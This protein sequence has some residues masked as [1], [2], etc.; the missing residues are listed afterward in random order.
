MIGR[1]LRYLVALVVCVLLPLAGCSGGGSSTK[2]TSKGTEVTVGGKVDVAKAVA[3]TAFLSST[4]AGATNNVF[5]YN[6]QDGAQLGTAVIGSDGSF[7]NLTF[8]LPAT[9]TVLVFKAVVAQGTFRSLVPVDL[10]SPPAAGVITGSNPINIQISQQST[11]ITRAVSALMGLTGLLGDANQTLASATKTYTD[12]AQA[13]VNSGGQILAYSTSGLALSGT[14]SNG[15]LLPARAAST[16]T[17]DDLNNTQLDGRIISAYIPGNNPI[18]NFQVV[19]KATGKGIAGLRTFGLHVAQLKPETAGSNSYWLNYI[20]TGTNPRPSSDPVTTFNST[21][22]AVNVQGYTV[23][24]HGD[25][26]Y[27]AIFGSN[28]KNVSSV[29]YD[30]TLVHRIGISVRSVAVPG[31]VGKTP[32]AYAGPINPQTNAVTANFAVRGVANLIYDFTPAT[33]A[34][35]TNNGAQAFA[36]DIVTAD[37]CNQCHDKLGFS[38]GHFASRPDTKLC[39]MCHTPQNIIG[40][41]QTTNGDFTSF[42]HKIH[43]GEELAPAETILGVSTA[44]VTYP[45]DIRN[46]AMCHKGVDGNNWKTKPTRKACGSCHSATDFA[47]H[48]GGQPTDTSCAA[49][50]TG[51][52]A[53]VE[54]SVAHLPVQDPDPAAPEFGGSNTHTYAGYLPAAGVAV[55]GA[56]VI[57]WDVKSVSR[58]GN[59]NPVIVFRFKKDGVPVVFNTYQAGVVTELMT[60]YTGS[61]SAYFAFG[62]TQDNITAPA[63][64]NAAASAYIKNVWN[65]TTPGTT[66]TL[67]AIGTDGY[68]TLTIKNVIVPDGATMLTGGIGYTYGSATTPL[69]QTD[70]SSLT[71]PAAL[72][73]KWAYNGTNNQ[74]GL[75]VVTPNVWKVATGYT[76]RRTIVSN[77]KCN[78]CHVALGIAPTFHAGQ[79]NDAP[80][81]SFCHNVN[82]VN[83]G[84]GVNAKDAIHAI[85]AGAKRTNKY[86]WEVSAGDK[87]WEISYPGYLRDCEQCHVAGTY[88]FSTTSAVVPNLLPTTVATGNVPATVPTIVTGSETVPGTY[89]APQL[90]VPSLKGQALGAGFSFAGGTGTPTDAV[91]TT[92]IISPIS[93]ACYSCHDTAQAAAHMVANGGSIYEARSTALLKT[94]TCLVCHGTAQNTLNTT[95]PTIKAVHRWW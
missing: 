51:G 85:H 13:V 16:L 8:T 60:G 30:G 54:V 6:A 55:P 52:I 27:T 53:D 95:V 38:G 66:A 39:V 31:V 1:N 14:L 76:A 78:A 33:G 94:E 20:L 59:K 65:G 80:T 5:V 3:K 37:A 41:D 32:G 25:G 89:Y 73:T 62:V 23:I 74:G 70:L 71:V 49:C 29:P 90:N 72:K 43:M 50:H 91:G 83:S 21:T 63:D 69:T 61:P 58:D 79:R 86:S 34:M 64:Y 22:G 26:S 87:Y 45:Q 56:P 92:L 24:D 42:I 57:T 44:E 28:V 11:D 40:T 35:L 15:D 81:C 10:S 75:I 46:C 12:C 9:K 4:S 88:D 84:W 18:V 36:R 17:Y 67:S 68:Y 77:A 2:I 48:K 47:T 93:A 7:S 19:N 82:K